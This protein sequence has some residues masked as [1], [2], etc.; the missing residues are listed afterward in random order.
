MSASAS[1][2]ARKLP[3][4]SSLPPS[5]T[6][7]FKALSLATVSLAS[8]T[9]GLGLSRLGVLTSR[10][11][12]EMLAWGLLVAAADL[13]ALRV[14]R[15]IHVGLAFPLLLAA[16]FLFGPFIAG[17]LAMIASTDPREWRREMS[18]HRAVFNHA[19]IALSVISAGL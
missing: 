4:D 18:L 2:L 5:E 15:N 3:R 11:L 8:I 10:R 1:V 12:W 17:L 16:A 7:A 9:L 6:S 13:V 19:Q 14:W